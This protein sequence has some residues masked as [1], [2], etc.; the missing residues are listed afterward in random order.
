M[1][2]TLQRAE[3]SKVGW[4]TTSK[5]Q[6]DWTCESQS[7]K[8][9]I[10]LL[11]HHVVP[12]QGPCGVQTKLLCLLTC[13]FPME[14]SYYLPSLRGPV[15][16]IALSS[17][18]TLRSMCWRSSILPGDLGQALD[19]LVAHLMMTYVYCFLTNGS[20]WLSLSREGW[21]CGKTDEFWIEIWGS[22]PVSDF[23]NFVTSLA[24]HLHL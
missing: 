24:S 23:T 10:R 8:Y 15:P 14:K 21:W 12:D 1:S 19:M 3:Y 13:L 7:V 18:V 5:K 20:P 11:V 2:T 17:S 6:E 9:C 22:N 4:A 16:I